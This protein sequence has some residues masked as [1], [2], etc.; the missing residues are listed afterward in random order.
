MGHYYGRDDNYLMRKMYQVFKRLV[1][2]TKT[3]NWGI[4]HSVLLI[5][6]VL[7]IVGLLGFIITVFSGF[8][9]YAMTFDQAVGYIIILLIVMAISVL[10]LSI[11]NVTDKRKKNKY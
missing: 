11:L 7:D 6:F 1:Y 9:G 4:I 2:A 5:A 3:G 10:C 8:L